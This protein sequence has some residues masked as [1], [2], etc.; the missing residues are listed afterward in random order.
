MF[1]FGKRSG[2]ESSSEVGPDGQRVGDPC[3][4]DGDPTVGTWQ[5][6]TLEGGQRHWTCVR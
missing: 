3:G 2:R 6:E 1:S 4:P 5:V